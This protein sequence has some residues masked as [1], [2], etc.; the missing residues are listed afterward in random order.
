LRTVVGD[1]AIAMTLFV[2]DPT[3]LTNA[4]FVTTDSAAACFFLASVY[5]FYRYVKAPSW[6]RMIVCSLTFGTAL[7]S[8]H[9]AVLL[10]PI[11]LLLATGELAGRWYAS[12]RKQQTW[13]RSD[14]AR[15]LSLIIFTSRP[16][17]FFARERQTMSRPADVF[18]LSP[19]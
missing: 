17:V 11:L 5:A 4:P 16:A 13:S 19:T 6:Q 15:F 2:F 14:A 7:V 12:R 9:S 3:V 10:L 8:K 18:H 1:T